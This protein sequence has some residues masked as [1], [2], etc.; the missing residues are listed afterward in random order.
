MLIGCVCDDS[1][2]RLAGWVGVN[3]LWPLFGGLDELEV[4][5]LRSLIVEVCWICF[6]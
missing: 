1:L 6:G 3:L 2:K 5:E 4:V